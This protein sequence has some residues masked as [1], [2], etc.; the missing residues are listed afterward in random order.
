[1]PKPFK[2]V[3]AMPDGS[4]AT[5]VICDQADFDRAIATLADIADTVTLENLKAAKHLTLAARG[6]KTKA[7]G[8]RTLTC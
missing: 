6:T 4:K 5:S 8:Q 3:V 2:T 7:Q 1:M